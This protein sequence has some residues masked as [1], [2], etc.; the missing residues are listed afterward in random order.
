[1]KEIFTIVPFTSRLLVTNIDS[2]LFSKYTAT[3]LMFGIDVNII[4]EMY[5]TNYSFNTYYSSYVSVQIEVE[6]FVDFN[7]RL[8]LVENKDYWFYLII[9]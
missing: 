9:L 6:S 8:K 3:K 7:E 4:D 1:M 5:K 2:P